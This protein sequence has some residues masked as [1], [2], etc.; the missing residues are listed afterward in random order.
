[1]KR[2][3]LTGIFLFIFFNSFGQKKE[4][5]FQ[6]IIV[7]EQNIPI[8]DVMVSV[9]WQKRGLLSKIDGSFYIMANPQDTLVFKHTSFEPKAVALKSRNTTDTLKIQLTERT[10]I[11]DEVQITNW[12]DW[13]DFKHKIA[14]MNSDSI[15]KTNEYRL[16]MMFGAKKRH[17]VNNPYFRGREEPKINPLTIIGG[18]F[19]GGLPRMLYNKYSKTE[20][21]RRKIQEE[22]LQELNVRNNAYR[23]SEKKLQELLHIKGDK[24]KNFKA[25]CDYSLDFSKNNYELIE[26]IKNLYETWKTQKTD[27][28]DSTKIIYQPI[29]KTPFN[30]STSDKKE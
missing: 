13:Q 1:M 25:Y 30:S 21:I 23:Y 2:Y 9:N 29:S 12:G 7:D 14:T 24:L 18:I 10:L 3:F 20:K 4:T 22:K 28:I 19:S 26:Q 5:G 6:G 16:E 11:L 15:R 8:A 17:P 27:T